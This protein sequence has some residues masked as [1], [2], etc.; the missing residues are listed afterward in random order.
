M[1]DE[2]NSVA[3]SVVSVGGGAVHVALE[4]TEGARTVRKEVG[5]DKL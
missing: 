2:L 3:V 5:V 4:N 1:C